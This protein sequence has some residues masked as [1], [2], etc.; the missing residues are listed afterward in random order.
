[1]QDPQFQ[2]SLDLAAGSFL[3]PSVKVAFSLVLATLLVRV[4]LAAKV[5]PRSFVVASRLG[6]TFAF[7]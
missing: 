1:M 6:Q 2:L 3:R 5:L 7:V 4:K